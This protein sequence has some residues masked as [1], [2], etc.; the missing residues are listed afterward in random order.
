[1]MTTN[2][3]IKIEITDDKTAET[4]EKTCQSIDE[5]KDYLTGFEER[6]VAHSVSF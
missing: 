5:A 3:E 1:M 4:F 2:L 6:Q